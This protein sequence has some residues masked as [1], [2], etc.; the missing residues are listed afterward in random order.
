M[1]PRP[2]P[3]HWQSVW[4]A[5]ASST[6]YCAALLLLVGCDFPLLPGG[7]SEQ[8]G[9]T[10]EEPGVF[11]VVADEAVLRHGDVRAGRG[12]PP[13]TNWYVATNYYVRG[14]DERSDR[15]IALEVVTKIRAG[16]LDAIQELLGK[17]D[18]KADYAAVVVCRV[19]EP[20]AAPQYTGGM[21]IELTELF[22]AEMPSKAIVEEA[23]IYNR[24]EP[25]YMES[26][27]LYQ[28]MV[29]DHSTGKFEHKKEP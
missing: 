27:Y 17:H 4:L 6:M 1:N 21:I 24:P 8:R 5:F 23:R 9:V 22:D 7:Y 19:G 20:Y 26:G 12:L 18:R 2:L 14:A 10:L 13:D 3:W 29:I 15:E 28:P 11:R 16:H 25:H